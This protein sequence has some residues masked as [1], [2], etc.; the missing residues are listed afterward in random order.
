MLIQYV[1]D[2]FNNPIGAVVA[3]DNKIGWSRC[4]PKDQFSKKLAILIAKG[5]MQKHPIIVCDNGAIILNGTK[6][7][8]HHEVVPYI[9]IMAERAK[10]YYK[11]DYQNANS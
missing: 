1:R 5:R 3:Q 11:K 8:I 2:E 10:R 9:S 6:D 7:N 4:S